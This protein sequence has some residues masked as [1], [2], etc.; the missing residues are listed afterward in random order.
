VRL[1]RQSIA[2][3]YA[4][5]AHLLKDTDLDS[6]RRREDYAAL[7]WDL[8]DLPAAAKPTP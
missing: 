3:G 6:L 8:A 2:R 5:V 1:L 4:D 7:L